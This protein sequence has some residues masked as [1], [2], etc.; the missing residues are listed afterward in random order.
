MEQLQNIKAITSYP[1]PFKYEV[2]M[3]QGFFCGL[4][5]KFSIH[6]NLKYMHLSNDVLHLWT[7]DIVRRMMKLV[8]KKWTLLYGKVCVILEFKVL[9]EFVMQR[10]CK[11]QLHTDTGLNDDKMQ[12]R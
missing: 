2:Y 10:T 3:L 9:F 4:N 5:V 8:P 6:P 11:Q 12:K 1:Y 7:N